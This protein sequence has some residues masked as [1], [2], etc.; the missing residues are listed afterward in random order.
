MCIRDREGTT[1][2][3]FVTTGNTLVVGGVTYVFDDLGR[4]IQKGNL[5]F[6]Y[7]PDGQVA[8]ATRGTQTWEFL[9][10]EN[11]QRLLKRAQ[12]VPL[13]AYL[14]GGLYLDATSL[15]EPV[16]VDG[17]LVGLLRNGVFRM[18]A[19]DLRGTFLAD[20]DGTP[21]FVS[22][23]GDRSPHPDMAAAFDFVQKS[24]DA[25]LGLIRM[26]VRDY[27]PSINRFLTPDPLF[28]EEPE[29]C[30]GSP[31]ECNLYVYAGANPV[32]Y[33]DPTGQYLESALDAISLGAGLYSISQWDDKTSKLDKAMDVGGVILDGVSLALPFV[34]GGASLGLKAL[35]G[36][37]KAV[38]ALHKADQ[39]GDVSKGV[40]LSLIHI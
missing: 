25:D 2:R 15:T 32:M 19:S 28:L 13:A 37:E 14:E 16:R 39:L 40:H 8:Q 24:Y 1:S 18:V 34:P 38:E 35:R 3:G 31:V 10:D 17:Q 29:R 5:S 11:G 4:T 21:R 23:F 7:G 30:V 12:G 9:H 36:G 6:T 33:A 20:E 22:P 27:D 26:G